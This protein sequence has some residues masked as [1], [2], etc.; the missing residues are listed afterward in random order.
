M[1]KSLLVTAVAAMLAASLSFAD[2]SQSKVVIPVNKT[3]PTDGKQMYT[4]YC[5]PCH[6]VD[7]KG[8]GPAASALKARPTDLTELAKKTTTGNSQTRISSRFCSL[9]RMFL[10]TDQHDAHMGTDS[11]YHEQDQRPGQAAQNQQSEPLPGEHSGTVTAGGPLLP[12]RNPEGADDKG[13]ETKSNWT[14]EGARSHSVRRRLFHKRR[15]SLSKPAR[16]RK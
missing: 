15:N 4:S 1:L 6:G 8:N 2:Q 16:S 14:N 5:A 12:G 11:W 10:H 3:S 9:V 13:K 7:G